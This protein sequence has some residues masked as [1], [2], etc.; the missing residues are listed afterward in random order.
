MANL[1]VIGGV[2]AGMSAASKARRMDPSLRVIALERTPFMSYG[3]C[4]MPYNLLRPDAPMEQ[5]I[6]ISPREF[7]EKRGIDARVNVQVEAIDTGNRTV[8]ARDL[9]TGAIETLEWDGLVYATGAEAVRPP[10][11]G[12]DLKGVF[13]MRDL[14]DGKLVKDYLRRQSPRQAAVI[15]GGYIGLEM[16]HVLTEMGLAVTVIEK[17][18]SI[19]AGWEPEA[20]EPVRKSLAEG[21]VT[22]LEGVTVSGF[23]GTDGQVR[24]VETDGPEVPADLVVVAVGIRPAAALAEKSGIALGARGAVAV[25]REMK[26]NVP[27][28]WAAGDCA[29]QWH[30][31][32]RKNVWVPLGT[33]ANKQGRIAGENAA[34]GHAIWEGMIGSAVFRTLG[35]DAART[36][37][38]R[39]EAREAGIEVAVSSVDG[40]DAAHGMT[41]RRPIRIVL[42]SR[43]DNGRVVG[44]QMVGGGVAK[45]C[46]VLATAIWAGMTVRDVGNLD[47]T[48]APPFSPVWDPILVAANVAEKDFDPNDLDC[49]FC[50]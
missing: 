9:R 23:N 29:E 40:W 15:G 5:L 21:G 14:T 8:T 13:A 18:P 42:V 26:T 17:M 11:P 45:R 48:Y 25:D 2:A 20:I 34:G 27:G 46:D 35:I 47:L 43:K 36:G 16:A 6:A 4:G 30:R 37:I 28:I 33:N 12:M 19:L 1:I 10:W 38:G 24:T 41:E 31:L 22:V 39:D 3:S 44:A 50:E 32:L 49:R 7:R